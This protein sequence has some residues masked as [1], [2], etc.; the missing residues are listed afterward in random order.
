MMWASKLTQEEL[1]ALLAALGLPVEGDKAALVARVAARV[2][3]EDDH[4]GAGTE[5][6]ACECGVFG[7]PAGVSG[8]SGVSPWCVWCVSLVCLVC[9][10]C[11]KASTGNFFGC[12]PTLQLRF[13]PLLQNGS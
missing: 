5:T 11:P 9:L 7:S 1:R 13:L 4:D 10:A 8:V 12:V 2:T 3:E 6:V